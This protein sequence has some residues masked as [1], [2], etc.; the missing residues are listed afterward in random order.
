MGR[1]RHRARLARRVGSQSWNRRTALRH[2]SRGS[3][4]LRCDRVRLGGSGRVGLYGAGHS[5]NTD[6]PCDRL[7]WRVNHAR[8]RRTDQPVA[9]FVPGARVHGRWR[10]HCHRRVDRLLDS[11]G[12]RRTYRS[13]DR[14]AHR[15]EREDAI[16][17][18]REGS[19]CVQPSA[20]SSASCFCLPL[21]SRSRASSRARWPWIRQA[22]FGLSV[23]SA[24]FE[25]RHGNSR[26]SRSARGSSGRSR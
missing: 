9:G 22:R 23:P 19:P 15:I 17:I 26:K 8:S 13:D 2:L 5:R 4:H 3:A 21:S 7:A 6:R 18:A 12:A 20:R 24:A 25:S 16:C 14:H 1:R 11:C 10:S